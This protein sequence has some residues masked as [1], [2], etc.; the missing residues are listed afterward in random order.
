[1]K[2]LAQLRLGEQTFLEM[3]STTASPVTN[4]TTTKSREQMIYQS[5][6]AMIALIV[7]GITIIL[8]ILLIILKTCNRKTRT[9]RILGTTRRKKTT[10]STAQTNL[11]MSNLRA[12]TPAPA[13]PFPFTSSSMENGRQ[14]PTPSIYNNN[15]NVFAPANSNGQPAVVTIHMA[16]AMDIS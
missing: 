12:G 2:A 8:C 15:Y 14:L 5:A 4:S 1:M 16:N 7:I 9:S 13:G 6:G 10:S 11:A 3:T